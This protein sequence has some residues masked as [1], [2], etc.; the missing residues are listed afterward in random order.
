MRS[1][2]EPLIEAGRTGVV[3]ICAD[4]KCRRIHPILAAYIADHPEQCLV[5][6]CQQNRCPKCLVS[7][8]DLGDPIPS[9][10][11]DPGDTIKTLHL[12]ANG[13]AP[14]AFAKNGLRPVDPFWTDLPFCDIF[15]SFTPD[16]LHQLHKGVFKDHLVKWV[17]K[18]LDHGEHEVDRRFQAM[19]GHPSLR[20][21]KKGISLV[22][23]WTGNE[24]KNMEKV[25]LGVVANAA[26]SKVVQATCAVLDFIHYAHFETHTDRSLQRLEDAWNRFHANKDEFVK[27]EVRTHFNIP[28]VHAM[29]HYVHMIRSH[30]TADGFNTEASE[31]LHIDFAKHAYAAS[32]RKD[33]IVQM[34]T[35][36]ARREAIDIFSEYLRW[37]IPGYDTEADPL[38]EGPTLD[39][40]ENPGDDEPSEAPITSR[41]DEVSYSVAVRPPFPK[42]SVDTIVS[43]FRAP[44]FLHCLYAFLRQ[45]DVLLANFDSINPTTVNVP[46]YK[47]LNLLIPNIPEVSTEGRPTRD[48]V[49]ACAATPGQGLKKGV[50]GVFDTVFARKDP[51]TGDK[52]KWWSSRGTFHSS[53]NAQLLNRL[54]DLCVAQVRVIF[55]L[56]PEYGTFPEPL[57]YVEWFKPLRTPDPEHGM[58]KTSRSSRQHRRNASIIP[59][60][61]IARSCHLVPVFGREIDTGWTTH[62]VLEESKE[63]YVNHYLRH[64]DFV[65]MRYL[66]L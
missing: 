39:G 44:D 32:N 66:G 28:K 45:R 60:S 61:Q 19:T 14:E 37:S 2:L 24:H 9:S 33:Y 21:F 54:R 31:R 36:L 62:N 55:D 7:S 48:V 57:A 26:N 56:P 65:L 38:N 18:T 22:S 16:I 1:L 53:S 64:L 43:K 11:R 29:Q 46:V 52:L 34:K 41:S 25:F 58:Y 10:L 20:H 49:R 12:A 4:G 40:D 59:A 23:Q 30:G 47:R 42:T 50:P 13:Y 8:N 35:W 6:C 63:F 51:L 27:Q 17:T 15:L 5:A 3:M